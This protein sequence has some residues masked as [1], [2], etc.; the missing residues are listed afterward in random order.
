MNKNYSVKIEKFAERHFIK[1]FEKKYKT[2]WEITLRAI[3][4]EL[5]RIDL[6][7][8]TSRAEVILSKEK[9]KLIKTEFRVSGTKESAK[10]SGNRCIVLCDENSQIVYVLLVY[11]K[12]DLSG[13]NETTEWKNI[14]KNNYQNYSYLL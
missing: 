4:A 3:I 9:I 5:E 2:H 7:I 14:I 8:K 11:S 13:H 12:S 6:L 10:S 1:S